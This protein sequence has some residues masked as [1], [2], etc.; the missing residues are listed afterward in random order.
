M[1]RDK[2]LDEILALSHSI[3]E[4]ARA[5]DWIGG[6]QQEQYR[7]TLMKRCFAPDGQ[8][9]DRLAASEKIAQIL[10]TDRQTLALGREQRQAVSHSI[11]KLR[12]GRAAVSAYRQVRR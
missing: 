7:Q 4:L 9:A 1:N 3:L 6:Q 11:G 5:G 10:Q 8:F 12:Q 2:L